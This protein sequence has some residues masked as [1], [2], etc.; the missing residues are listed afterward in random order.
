M[1][2]VFVATN[3]KDPPVDNVLRF[4]SVLVSINGDNGITFVLF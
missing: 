4:F 3:A 2:N 1:L